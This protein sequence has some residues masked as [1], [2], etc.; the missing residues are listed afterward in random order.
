MVF[1][2]LE[3]GSTET[4]VLIKIFS[5]F[6]GEFERLGKRGGYLKLGPKNIYSEDFI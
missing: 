3:L 5:K 4:Q 6:F 1:S 2:K